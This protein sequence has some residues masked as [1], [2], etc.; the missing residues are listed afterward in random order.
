MRYPFCLFQIIFLYF[1]QTSIFFCIMIQVIS[2][3]F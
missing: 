1:Q 2:Q 3:P